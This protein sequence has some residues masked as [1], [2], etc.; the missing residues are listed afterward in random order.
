[1]NE[2]AF[3]SVGPPELLILLIIILLLF[4]GRKLPELA[5]SLGRS[6]GEFRKGKEEGEREDG[7]AAEEAA[8]SKD[9]ES[10]PGKKDTE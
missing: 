4:G 2:L 10:S 3:V 1:M 9:D 5:R 7:G 8:V 6:L